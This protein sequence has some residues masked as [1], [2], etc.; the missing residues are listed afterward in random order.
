MSKIALPKAVVDAGFTLNG[1][2]PSPR[3]HKMG[4]G[5]V[6]LENLTVSQA[7]RL[8]KKGLPYLKKKK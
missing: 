2:P 8:V 6:D 1:K 4:F 7:E 3:F 5:D